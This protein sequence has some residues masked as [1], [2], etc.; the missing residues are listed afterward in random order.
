MYHHSCVIAAH[1]SLFK[2]FIPFRIKTKD[3]RLLV[4]KFLLKSNADI[5]YG[6]FRLDPITGELYLAF[7]NIFT[8]SQYE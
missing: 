6:S 4:N 2:D 3:L 7:S 5:S 1:F 8:T